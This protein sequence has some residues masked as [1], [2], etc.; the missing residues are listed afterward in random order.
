MVLI[1]PRE[2][3]TIL[4]TCP[5]AF[6]WSLRPLGWSVMERWTKNQWKISLKIRGAVRIIAFKE[7]DFLPMKIT[8]LQVVLFNY[9]SLAVLFPLIYV[10]GWPLRLLIKQYLKEK[11]EGC[12]VEIIH[13][14]LLKN[15]SVNLS[16]ELKLKYLLF[17]KFARSNVCQHCVNFERSLSIQFSESEVRSLAV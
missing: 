16:S 2:I 1:Y 15:F 9:L 5:T 11:W 4:V 7:N 12:L 14:L 6:V 8:I 3:T 10:M 13:F 17:A